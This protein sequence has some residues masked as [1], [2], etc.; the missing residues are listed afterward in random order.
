MEEPGQQAGMREPP[1]GDGDME[2]LHHRALHDRLSA[3]ES[4]VAG[5]VKKGAGYTVVPAWKR[6]TK[7]ELRWP[8]TI[9]L[10]TALALQLTL[11]D[12]LVLGPRWLMP[13]LG[14]LLLILILAT[15]P[16]ARLDRTSMLLR[17]LGLA[18]IATISVANFYSAAKLIDS[19]LNGGVSDATKLLMHGGAIWLTNVIVFALWYWDFDRGGPVARALA[20][21][22]YPD[23]QFPQMEN[24]NLAPKDW[25]PLFIDYLYTSFTNAT[26]FSPTDV[27]PLSRWAKLTMLLQSSLSI[28]L[29]ALVIA[30]A[31][32][33]LK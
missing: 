28:L 30:R 31:V 21:K 2:E 16:R 15:N 9:A 23:F 11:P 3:L 10:A 1:P 27:M 14:G 29:V 7:G 17:G 26:A 5:G 18:I 20:M 25:E 32:N 22:P 33:I 24:P 8:V 19:L 13:S 4:Q 12:A 6:L